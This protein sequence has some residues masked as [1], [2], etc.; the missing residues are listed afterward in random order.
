VSVFVYNRFVASLALM[1][2]AAAVVLLLPPVRRSLRRT[3]FGD[4]ATWLAVLVALA[5]TAGSLIYSEWF[6][7]EP[8]RL[9]WYQRIAMYPLVP[10]L[11][12]GAIRRDPAI[13]FYGL[14]LSLVGAGIAIWHYLLQTFPELDTGAC[15]VGVPCT[16]KYVNEFGF[17]SIPLMALSAFALISVLLLSFRPGTPVTLPEEIDG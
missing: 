16:A 8:C 1:S 4:L 13:R 2:M 3:G 7:F 5:A 14:P 15:S 9:C 6:G 12:V 17:V 10:V 11:A